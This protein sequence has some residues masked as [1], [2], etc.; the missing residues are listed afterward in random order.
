LKKKSKYTHVIDK[1]CYQCS[2]KIYRLSR[3]PTVIVNM[4]LEEEG[5]VVVIVW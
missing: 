2:T 5:V 4:I 3:T 1:I